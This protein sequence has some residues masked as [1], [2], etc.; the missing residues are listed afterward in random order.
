MEQD[1]LEWEADKVG[2]GAAGDGVV[3][4]DPFRQDRVVSVYVHNAAI[5]NLIKSE[6]PVFSRNARNAELQ[7]PGNK[8]SVRK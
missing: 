2:D 3:W 8:V 6:H 1:L 7:W 4:V 5:R